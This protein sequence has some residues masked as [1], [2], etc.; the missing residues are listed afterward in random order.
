MK[1]RTIIAGCIAMFMAVS[2]QAIPEPNLPP[3]NIWI[4]PSA[5]TTSD[6]VS[7]FFSGLWPDTCVPEQ[8]PVAVFAGDSVW[9][10]VLLPGWDDPNECAC[11]SCAPVPTAFEVE[12][13]A[14]YLAQGQYDVYARVI[15]CEGEGKYEA[16]SGFEVL[17]GKPDDVA[18]TGCQA[19]RFRPGSRVV[20]LTD[21]PPGGVGLKAGHAGTVICQ[22]CRSGCG[23]IL[24]SW[25]LWT[26]GHKDVDGCAAGT[27]LGFPATSGLWI[28][29]SE[30]LVGRP[31]HRAGTIQR[32]LE[33]CLVFVADNRLEYNVVA[34]GDMQRIL[35]DVAAMGTGGRIRIQGLLNETS[36]KSDVIRICPQRS[37][38]IYHPIVS[39]CRD[40]PD[41][42]PGVCDLDLKPGDRVELLVDRPMGAGGGPAVD[43]FAGAMGTVICTDSTDDDLP[44][45]VSWDDWTNGTDTDYFCDSIVVPYVS[46]S[47]CWMR[48]NEVRLVHQAGL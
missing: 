10:D 40:L 15:S 6:N 32:G 46:G 12:G 26:G 41:P 4:H 43:L 13:I 17:A 1:H 14:G 45:Y 28:D 39:A 8:I 33:G 21:D 16:V 19:F 27:A 30:V 5:P 36:P 20:L 35:E 7:I 2:V 48:C 18:C 24:V 22:D 44:F 37:G 11:L 29:L 47:G 3:V 31:F 34:T 9:I 38:D 42:G 25:D 23:R